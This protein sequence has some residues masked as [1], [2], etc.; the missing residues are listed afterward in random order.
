MMKLHFLMTLLSLIAGALIGYSFRV[1]DCSVLLSVIAGVEAGILLVFGT[2]V[3]VD[4]YPRS[5]MMLKTAA[6][7]FFVVLLSVNVLLGAFA[8]GQ[9]AIIIING[10]ILLLAIVTLYKVASSRV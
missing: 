10:L 7:T 8:A 6:L 5:S 4:G 3:S 1:L 2:A 9:H